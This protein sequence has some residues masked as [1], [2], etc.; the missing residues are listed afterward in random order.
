MNLQNGAY[1]RNAAGAAVH[2]QLE[3]DGLFHI[4]DIH[5]STVEKI[6]QMT[7]HMQATQDAGGKGGEDVTVDVKTH[8]EGWKPIGKAEFDKDKIK[9][10][11]ADE[12]DKGKKGKVAKKPGAKDEE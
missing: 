5:G 4:Y 11:D 1:Y 8:V 3:A 12:K 2:C 7:E 9:A 6:T 10:R